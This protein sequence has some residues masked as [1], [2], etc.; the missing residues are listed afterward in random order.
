MEKYITSPSVGARKEQDSLSHATKRLTL[1]SNTFLP[2]IA[3][4]LLLGRFPECHSGPLSIVPASN[5][6]RFC[7]FPGILC[8]FLSVH[9]ACIIPALSS[10]TSDNIRQN[11]PFPPPFPLKIT[12]KPHFSPFFL[13]QFKKMLYLCTRN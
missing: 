8:R 11:H 13:A 7:P 5:A 9:S 2:G 4:R 12:P 10:I 1:G 3:C 6:G